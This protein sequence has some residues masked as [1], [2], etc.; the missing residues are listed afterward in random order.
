MVYGRYPLKAAF[1]GG[2]SSQENLKK[3]K[4]KKGLQDVCFSKGRGLSMKDMCRRTG[5]TSSCGISAQV[6]NRYILA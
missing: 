3:A 5:F 2:F 1:D 4:G 6:L